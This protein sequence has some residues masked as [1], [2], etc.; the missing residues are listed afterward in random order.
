MSESSFNQLAKLIITVLVLI[1]TGIAL[2]I[3]HP[4]AQVLMPFAGTVIGYWFGVS[5]PTPGVERVI[6]VVPAQPLEKE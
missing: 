6:R 1:V 4:A 2:V 3:G 5:Q